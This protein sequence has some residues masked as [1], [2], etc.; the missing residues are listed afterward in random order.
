[1]QNA[2][3][4]STDLSNNKEIIPYVHSDVDTVAANSIVL[5]SLPYIDNV[6]PDYEAYALTLI[7]EEMQ[8]MKPRL[9]AIDHLFNPLNRVNEGVPLSFEKTIYQMNKNEYANIIARDGKPRTN[10]IDYTKSVDATVPIIDVTDDNALSEW[11]EALRQAK[12][13]LEHERIRLANT[14]LLSEFESSRWKH[15][16]KI[17]EER[18]SKP[19]LL[20]SKEEQMN[21]DAINSKR[22]EMQETQVGPKLQTLET[23][24]SELVE[25]NRRL[26]RAKFSL[27]QEVEMLKKVSNVTPETFGGNKSKVKDNN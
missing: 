13:E 6:H 3:Q 26:E 27:Q 17:L 5:D 2:Q 19:M 14:E 22:K 1:M 25:K 18:Y 4:S 9:N 23:R 12:I 16:N 11:E 15:H 10:P 7:E 24:W 8:V 21:V 20:I